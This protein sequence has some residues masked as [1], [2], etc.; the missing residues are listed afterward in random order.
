MGP[1][2]LIFR[3]GIEIPKSFSAQFSF[4]EHDQGLLNRWTNLELQGKPKTKS[5][6][7]FFVQGKSDSVW[8]RSNFAH[9]TM[10]FNLWLED[11]PKHQWIC[12]DK[13]NLTVNKSGGRVNLIQNCCHPNLLHG[14]WNFKFSTIT[15]FSIKALIGGYFMLQGRG[16]SYGKFQYFLCQAL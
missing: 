3:G 7:T 16:K 11:Y 15:T 14:Q 9:P 8:F 12:F 6:R 2:D 13:W 5:P 1:L 4:S 10:T